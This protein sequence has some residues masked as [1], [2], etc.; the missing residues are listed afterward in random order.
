M[1]NLAAFSQ[2]F[3][4]IPFNQTMLN[5]ASNNF[6]NGNGPISAVTA[7]QTNLNN[8]IKELQNYQSNLISS[9]PEYRD[10][11]LTPKFL[12]SIS[13]ATIQAS[14]LQKQ[15]DI[16]NTNILNSEAKMGGNMS[17]VIFYVYTTATIILGILCIVLIVYL[18]Y[19]YMEPSSTKSSNVSANSMKGGKRT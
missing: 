4:D 18:S 6:V 3:P 12:S 14:T 5:L 2:Q 19:I 8:Q 1:S 10:Q 17:A 15:I 7:F 11:T 13:T 16:V 9:T